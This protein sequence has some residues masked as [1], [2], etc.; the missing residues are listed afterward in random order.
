MR[1]WKMSQRQGVLLYAVRADEGAAMIHAFRQF[2]AV[3]HI[4]YSL[5]EEDGCN[6]TTARVL[7][8]TGTDSPR[9]YHHAKAWRRLS[10]TSFAFLFSFVGR[11]RYDFE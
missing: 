2:R 10:K 1:F 3:A 11:T 8:E 4:L 9:P 5:R 6:P 7:I